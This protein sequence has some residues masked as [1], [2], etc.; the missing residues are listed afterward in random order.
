MRKRLSIIYIF[1]LC[2][3]V[4]PVTATPYVHS[5][6]RV[7]VLAYYILSL[8]YKAIICETMNDERWSERY[9][10]CFEMHLF[11]WPMNRDSWCSSR[12]CIKFL[13][14]RIMKCH[15]TFVNSI[16]VFKIFHF[17]RC[18]ICRQIC[19]QW[20]G[21]NIHDHG[22]A[23]TPQFPHLPHFPIL[24]IQILFHFS[25]RILCVCVWAK[26]DF[27]VWIKTDIFV[28]IV[29]LLFLKKKIWKIKSKLKYPQ[30]QRITF[31]INIAH[32]LCRV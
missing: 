15:V 9:E 14:S 28:M 24:I 19:Y 23:T 27:I 16:K 2:Y 25:I 8:L 7:L 22:T 26:V 6:V 1:L 10:L 17:H 4:C 29:K 21:G 18:A 11:S 31:Y 30:Q 13:F 3:T 12:L 5:A 20:I 32:S